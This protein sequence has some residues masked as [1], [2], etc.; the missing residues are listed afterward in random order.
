MLEQ[1]SRNTHAIVASKNNVHE[2]W[3]SKDELTLETLGFYPVS[4][5]VLCL[6]SVDHVVLCRLFLSLLGKVN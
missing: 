6:L 2:L 4:I 3:Y 5:S 1:R